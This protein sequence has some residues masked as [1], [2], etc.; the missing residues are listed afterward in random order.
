M[1]VDLFDLAQLCAGQREKGMVDLQPHASDDAE[2]VLGH[3]IIDLVHGAGRTVFQRNDAVLAEALLNGGKNSVKGGEI[4]HVRRAEQLFTRLLRVR[5]LHALTGDDGLRREELRRV[6]DRRFNFL[7]QLRVCAE[8]PA[9]IPTAQLKDE[10]V[11]T[12]CRVF[13]FLARQLCDL[14]QLLPFASRV[15]DA[16]RVL[17]FV[18]RDLRRRLHPLDKERSQLCVNLVDFFTV[19]L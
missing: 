1:R 3:E 10:R 12:H 13:K 8:Q 14:A 5:A 2:A 11:Q 19:I 18:C 15:Q 7:R 17:F 9:L 16:K 6:L 4:E